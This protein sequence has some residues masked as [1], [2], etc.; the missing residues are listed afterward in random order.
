[1]MSSVT[2]GCFRVDGLPIAPAAA[3]SDRR[4]LLLLVLL[5]FSSPLRRTT[6]VYIKFC[7][8][9]RQAIWVGSLRGACQEGGKSETRLC[10]FARRIDQRGDRHT[11]RNRNGAAPVRLPSALEHRA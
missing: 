10:A 5:L 1:M 8:F 3:S 9:V 6:V 11:Y 7:Q 4:L 2:R